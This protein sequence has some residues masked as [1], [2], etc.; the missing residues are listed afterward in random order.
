MLRDRFFIYLFIFL[1]SSCFLFPPAL[2]KKSGVRRYP[3]GRT[4]W[5]G[6]SRTRALAPAHP[7]GRRPHPQPPPTAT[8]PRPR[9]RPPPGTKGAWATTSPG[10][11]TW[12]HPPRHGTDRAKLTPYHHAYDYGSLLSSL[13]PLLAMF[14][15]S[16]KSHQKHNQQWL[17]SDQSVAV[18]WALPE[19]TETVKG[20]LRRESKDRELHLFFAWVMLFC[21]L[22]LC[23]L[24]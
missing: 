22:L 3:R 20:C 5:M 11:T 8:S 10:C 4:S 14:R 1:V 15:K 9:S 17:L 12:T 23:C 2:T 21:L 6:Q 24:L 7:L 18:K 19:S 16:M 13:T